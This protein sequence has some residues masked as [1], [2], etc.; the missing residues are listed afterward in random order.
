MYKKPLWSNY[1]T[2]VYLMYIE[3]LPPPHLWQRKKFLCVARSTS[4]SHDDVGIDSRACRQCGPMRYGPYT[5]FL[6]IL[7]RVP[8]DLTLISRRRRGPPRFRARPLSP[9]RMQIGYLYM[10]MHTSSRP[11]ESES[12]IEKESSPR[13]RGELIADRF[14]SSARPYR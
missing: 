1:S 7:S 2:V 3:N 13:E 6:L 5:T 11:E 8:E 12:E 9:P 14:L 4:S 10:Y